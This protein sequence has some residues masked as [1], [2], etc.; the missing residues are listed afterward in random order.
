MSN[1]YHTLAQISPA[2]NVLTILYTVPVAT[3]TTVSSIVICNTNGGTSSTFRVSVAVGGAADNISQYIYYDLPI[4]NNDSFI[5]TGGMTF[6]AGDVVRVQA[7]NPNVSFT[8]F[9]VEMS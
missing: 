3:Q 1:N 4:L 5:F 6:N 9:G 7:A 8:L 2:E